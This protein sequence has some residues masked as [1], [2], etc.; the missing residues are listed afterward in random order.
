MTSLRTRRL[1]RWTAALALAAAGAGLAAT[2]AEAH[3]SDEVVQQ[4]YLT[5]TTTRLD[6]ELAITPGVLVA[7]TFAKSVDTDG[8]KVL[9]AREQAAHLDRVTSALALRVDGQ[10]V[11][12]AV[13]GSEYA[14][15]ALLAAAGGAVRVDLTAELPSSDGLGQVVFTND[16]DPGVRTT[17]QADVLVAA[18]DAVRPSGFERGDEGRAMT[19][20]FGT[21][22]ATD[23]TPAPGA[24][25]ADA[26]AEGSDGTMLSA[27]RTP[28][29]SPWA[30][31]VLI[32]T[33]ALLGAFHALTPG[34]GK[35]LLASYLVGANSTPRQAVALGAVITMTH[36]ASVIALGTLVLFAGA[37][38]VP[39]VLVPV[40]E[41]TAGAVVLVLG[42]RLLL[43]RWQQR[44]G[45]S[46]DHGHDH[47]HSHGEAHGHHHHA[48]LTVP[49]T[50]RGL[51]AMG[52]S[53]GIVP[54]P[55]ALG[56]LLLAIG[57]NRTALGLAMIVAFSVGLAGVLVGLGLILVSARTK[58]AGFQRPTRWSPLIRWVPMISAAVVTILGVTITTSG[59][60]ELLG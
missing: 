57:L 48:P 41:I 31:L 13:T 29:A 32:G 55:E 3:P 44:E 36:T 49:T 16:Y 54:C 34:H 8:D 12:L 18:V 9:D 26:D 40:L 6:V 33:C 7:P 17:V 15:Y 47:G 38:V 14:E 2:P 35:A 30:L 42:T 24:A 25:D 50:F 23:A 56:V 59:V 46:H 11:K 20:T 37:F 43:R 60:S 53:G 4:T 28:L 58:L 52:V 1:A 51:A 19:L 22:D 39:E 10:E 5:P 27:L 21:G 45:H